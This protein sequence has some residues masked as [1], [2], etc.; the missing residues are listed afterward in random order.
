MMKNK[1]F[2][3]VLAEFVLP[4]CLATALFGLIA[5]WPFTL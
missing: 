2:R 3:D 1:L 5:F 4:M